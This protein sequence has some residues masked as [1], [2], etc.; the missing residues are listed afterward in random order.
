M[1]VNAAGYH[2]KPLVIH[3]GAHVQDS[4]KQDMLE[5]TTLGVS[6]N[7]W[8]DKRLFYNYGKK[9][10]EYLRSIDQLGPDKHNL[11]LMDSHN[12]HT[13]NF[14]FI[15]LMNENNIHVLALPA[16]TTHCLQPLDDVPFANFKGAWYE[17]VR[18]YV[19]S[20]DP[21]T[22][23]KEKEPPKKKKVNLKE[24]VWE[25]ESQTQLDFEDGDF[26]P[27]P[28]AGELGKKDRALPILD[29]RIGFICAK[30]SLKYLDLDDPL[31]EESKWVFCPVCEVALH[32]TCIVS[33]CICKYKPLRRHINVRLLEWYFCPF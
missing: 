19:R 1:F 24:R 15:K 6:E 27:T 20:S 26:S 29:G 5:G 33:G 13:F 30:C 28:L 14:Q 32:T 12:S 17:G 10:I 3:K 16:H 11:L 21:L 2:L 23:P 8:I 31:P 25:P 4:W 7:G 22:T 9:L 18:Q